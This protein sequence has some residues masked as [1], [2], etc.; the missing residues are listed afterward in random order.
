MP[1]QATESNGLSTGVTPDGVLAT[2][3]TLAA[4]A[5]A[6]DAA[7]TTPAEESVASLP[8]WAQK[9]VSDLRQENA[10]RRKREQEAKVKADED[11]LAAERKWQ[12]LAEQR[13][14]EIAA[15]KTTAERYT[16][17]S[18]QL[19][20]Q[21][22][23]EIAQWPDEVKGLKP[24]GDDVEAIVE[25]VEKARPIV[26]KLKA[27]P[28]APGQG[29]APRPSAQGRPSAGDLIQRKRQSGDYVPI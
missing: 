6:Q 13:G 17:L 27:A 23:A 10:N 25:W 29:A 20:T 24:A 11:K 22:E 16:V 8:E 4:A 2:G 15:L 5:T 3:T 1:V 28:P 26:S 12:E 14:Q 19:R 7:P 9:M 18:G 21:V